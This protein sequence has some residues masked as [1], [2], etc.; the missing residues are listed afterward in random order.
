MYSG[1]ALIVSIFLDREKKLD[2]KKTLT[3]M[4]IKFKPKYINDR[5]RD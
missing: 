4:S 1:Q 3:N 2:K 5:L